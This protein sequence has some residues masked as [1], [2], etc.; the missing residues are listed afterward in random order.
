MYN[1]HLHGCIIFQFAD[2]S[3]SSREDESYSTCSDTTIVF[4][5]VVNESNQ[6]HEEDSAMVE[7]AKVSRV[8]LCTEAV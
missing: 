6:L 1:T 4:D 8:T 5:E 7:V 3:K 2:T